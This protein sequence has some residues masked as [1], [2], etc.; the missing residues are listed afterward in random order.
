MGQISMDRNNSLPFSLGVNFTPPT[1]MISRTAEK[2]KGRKK[3]RKDPESVRQLLCDPQR[4][5]YEKRQGDGHQEVNTCS[6]DDGRFS[7][8]PKH[9][10]NHTTC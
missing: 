6:L 5:N 2:K 10:L 1:L 9:Y 4:T 8:V 3:E 7:R